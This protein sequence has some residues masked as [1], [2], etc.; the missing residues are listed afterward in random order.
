[1]RKVPT[2]NTEFSSLSTIQKRIKILF[3][4]S[5]GNFLELYDYTLYAV[6]LS[7]ISPE[8]FPSDSNTTSLLFGMLSFALTM[9]ICPLSAWFWGWYGD[10][11]GRLPMLKQSIMLMALPSLLIG[12]LPNYN[13]IGVLAPILLISCRI[14]QAI[15]ASGEVMGGKIFAME[16]LGKKHF[17]SVAGFTSLGGSLGVGLAIAMGL[18]I[19]KTG[20]SWRIPFFVGG[21]LAIVGLM[22]RRKLAESPEFIH[23]LKN[24]SKNNNQEPNTLSII[25]NYRTEVIITLVLGSLLGMLS[26]MISAFLSPYLISLGFHK[27][28]AY[29]MGLIGLFTCAI[30]SFLTG[31]FIDIIG[32]VRKIMSINM[33]CCIFIFPLSFALI[34]LSANGYNIIML[35]TAYILL[36]GILGINAVCSSII[37]YQL[38]TPENRCRGVMI[39][40][41]LGVAIFGGFTPLILK[42]LSDI[43]H[44][45]PA[46]IL[47]IATIIIYYIYIKNM[48]KKYDAL[49]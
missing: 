27:E 32:N 15:S 10:K 20:I 5:V 13:E 21:S 43:N 48:R 47:T 7:V 29:S 34:L 42:L 26:Y 46:G 18:L 11:Y 31:K 14:L 8:F 23:L 33:L 41:A 25:K 22:I 49:S 44:A 28:T 3:F 2:D 17:G 16:H 38:F 9:L 36:G 6:I 1:M 30:T 35:Y 4:A 12:L 19:S 39:F 37:M 40:Y 45:F 24:M